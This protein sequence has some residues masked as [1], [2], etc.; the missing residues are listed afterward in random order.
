MFRSVHRRFLGLDVLPRH[1]IVDRLLH[2]RLCQ[3]KEAEERTNRRGNQQYQ[4]STCAWNFSLW[5]VAD[6][7]RPLHF[8]ATG[9]MLT[10]AALLCAVCVC[11]WCVGSGQQRL[12]TVSRCPTTVFGHRL[13]VVEEVRL[14]GGGFRL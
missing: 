11:V 2:L 3:L 4:S 6:P 10:T 13:H 1:E 7:L 14:L 8:A 12:V 5:L 9:T